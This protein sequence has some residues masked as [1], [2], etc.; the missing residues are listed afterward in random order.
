MSEPKVPGGTLTSDDLSRDGER[1]VTEEAALRPTG[2]LRKPSK[3][4][5]S[6]SVNDAV[7]PPST[8]IW[9]STIGI[10]DYGAGPEIRKQGKPWTWT[11]S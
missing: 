7:S 11:R 2:S 6:S 10:T 3:T 8:S 9:N 1:H 5:S 4:T